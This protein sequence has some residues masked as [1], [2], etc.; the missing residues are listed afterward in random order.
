VSKPDLTP[1]PSSPDTVIYA[2]TMDIDTEPT[3]DSNSQFSIIFPLPYRCLMLVGIGILGWATNLHGLH[4]LGVDT[5]HVLDIRRYNTV[6]IGYESPPI[7]T[8]VS[9]SRLHRGATAFAHPSSLYRPIYKIFITYGVLILTSWL[10]FRL[11][12]S[13]SPTEMDSSKIIPSLTFFAILISLFWPWSFS[14]RHER[15]TF[16]RYASPSIGF[17]G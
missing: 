2:R 14:Q 15:Y 1:T 10:L 13:S 3:I 4:F 16:L 11:M 17:T 12:S 5:S 7:P 9:S 8:T 6:E